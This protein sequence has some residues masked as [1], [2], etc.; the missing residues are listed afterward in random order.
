MSVDALLDHEDGLGL[1]ALVRRH[2]VSAQ[3]LRGGGVAR[4]LALGGITSDL[5]ALYAGVLPGAGAAEA[6]SA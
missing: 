2:E 6:G 5:G 1:A 4:L 3:E